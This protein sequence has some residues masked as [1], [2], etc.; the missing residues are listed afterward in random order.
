MGAYSLI[1]FADDLQLSPFLAVFLAGVS[2]GLVPISLAK[3]EEGVAEERRLLYVG[4]TR[5]KR[6]LQV[7]YAKG[8]GSRANRKRSR[9]LEAVWPKPE[10]PVSRT[11][12]YRQ[13]R[14][15]E[16]AEFA[17]RYPDDV[18]LLERL[19]AWRATTAAE[20]NRPAYTVFHDTTLRAIAIAKPARLAQLG[21]IKGI[22]STK[23][24]QWGDEVLAVVAG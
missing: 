10:K 21:R 9:F 5:A 8:N 23:L 18:E 7:S 15:Q 6:Y 2:E 17:E 20:M 14:A 16:S 12:S 19:V 11:T 1:V 24:A 13:R 22:G 3:G 4:I